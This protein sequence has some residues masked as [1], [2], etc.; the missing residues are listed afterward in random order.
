MRSSNLLRL[1]VPSLALFAASCLTATGS[2]EDGG[3]TAAAT[4]GASNGG[5]SAAATGGSTGGGTTGG[6]SSGGSSGGSTGSAPITIGSACTIGIGGGGETDT[7]TP[8]GLVCQITGISTS[9]TCQLPGTGAACNTTFGC[10]SGDN[11]VAGAKGSTCVQSCTTTSDCSVLTD[12][13][14]AT[15]GTCTTNLCG[16]GTPNGTAYYAPCDATGTDDGVCLPVTTGGANGTTHGVCLASG[17]AAPYATCSATRSGTGTSTLCSAGNYCVAL[18]AAAGGA[19]ACFP[20][21]SLGSMGGGTGPGGG[22]NPDAGANP[23]DGGVAPD[24]GTGSEDAGSPSLDGGTES[25][26]CATGATCMNA[27]EIA[28]AGGG[29]GK[30]GGANG[31]GVCVTDCAGGATCPATLTCFTVPVGNLGSYCIP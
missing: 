13:C 20:L 11:C 15:G 4:S 27:N 16:P 26:T 19:S 1:V 14:D 5:T 3:S 12:T 21:C 18:P 17:S 31:L 29:G 30:G 24:G 10:V 22:T 28:A 23:L 7:C 2:G 9:G 6:G 8:V 25:Y